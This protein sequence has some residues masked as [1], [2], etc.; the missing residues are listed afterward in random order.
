MLDQTLDQLMFFDAILA[1]RK[2]ISSD[3]FKFSI[4]G[5]EGPG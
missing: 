2:R 4:L 3:H 1:K 5:L